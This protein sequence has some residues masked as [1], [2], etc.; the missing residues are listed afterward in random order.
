VISSGHPFYYLCII[1]YI[2]TKFEETLKL[3]ISLIVL[4]PGRASRQ[5]NI[6]PLASS[7]S[8]F[9]TIA[10]FLG[11]IA[12]QRFF[13]EPW[14][15]QIA[16]AAYE[17]HADESIDNSGNSDSQP[18]P[19]T[20]AS[21]DK[22]ARSKPLRIDD[23]L[24]PKLINEITKHDSSLTLSENVNALDFS[25]A[26]SPEAFVPISNTISARAVK[27]GYK[28]MG[29]IRQLFDFDKSNELT[30]GMLRIHSLHTG[31]SLKARLFDSNGVINSKILSQLSHL[32]RCWRTTE[33]VPIDPK[34]AQILVQISA[35]YDRSVYLVSGHRAVDAIGTN[36]TSQHVLGKAA[37]IKVPGVPISTLQKLVV[38]L[39]ARGI[40]LYPEKR[41][42]HIDV[43]SSPKY[44]W[45]YSRYGT[46][47]PLPVRT[48]GSR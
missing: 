13:S 38:K 19:L 5:Y 28:T 12:L 31:E 45:I 39:G 10:P 34:L 41:F 7:L 36:P 3:R 1:A 18:P 42:I 27:Y 46:E 33:V 24:A 11:G 32:M 6:Y 37:D 26:G 20:I 8:V 21:L 25:S 48:D 23:T 4:S 9:M 35:T 30:G 47:I 17:T 22:T 16:K 2:L 44:F 29:R 40:G 43:R 15:V 14:G